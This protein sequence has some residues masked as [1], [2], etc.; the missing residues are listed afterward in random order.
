MKNTLRIR[1]FLLCLCGL[2]IT[3]ITAPNFFGQ[4]QI[5]RAKVTLAAKD[6]IT[7]MSVDADPTEAA[8]IPR[9]DLIIKDMC[10]DAAKGNGID[11]VN[12]Q[13]A[14]IGTVDAGPFELGFE[15]IGTESS[16]F[17]HDEIAGGL[18]AGEETWVQEFHFC[19]GW[20]PMALIP[21]SI[22]FTAIADPKY[23]MRSEFD[24]N[25]LNRIE[26][27]SKVPEMKESNNRMTVNKADLRPCTTVT[28]ID[29]PAPAGLKTIKPQITKP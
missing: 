4:A 29:R 3:A 19:C 27:K 8:G 23:Y 6:L 20:A 1:F 21:A 13:I 9:A 2:S 26:V 22:R 15:Y 17:A 25:P 7:Q 24:P 11:S 10:F 12:V 18:R 14:N 16:T 5:D 28:K